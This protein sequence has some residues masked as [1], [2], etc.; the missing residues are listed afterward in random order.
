MQEGVERIILG[1]QVHV[2]AP[3]ECL[4]CFN[5]PYMYPALSRYFSFYMFIFCL[6]NY[7]LRLPIAQIVL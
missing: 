5:V 7:V 3:V 4:H 6:H 2:R 1:V